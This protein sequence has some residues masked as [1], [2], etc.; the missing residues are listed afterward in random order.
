MKNGFNT[1]TR[2][3][4]E[5]RPG[6][7]GENRWMLALKNTYNTIIIIFCLSGTEGNYQKLGVHR[8]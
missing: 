6:R 8:E 7:K 5:E 2:T 3:G 1:P 4:M